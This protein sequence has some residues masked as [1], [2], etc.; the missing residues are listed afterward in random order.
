MASVFAWLPTVLE[1]AQDLALMSTSINDDRST[2][3]LLPAG[4]PPVCGFFVGALSAPILPAPVL[5]PIAA[6]V[7][8]DPLRFGMMLVLNIVIGM[9]IPRSAR[10]CSL[11]PTPGACGS[12]SAA[13]AKDL[14]FTQCRAADLSSPAHAVV[15]AFEARV[16]GETVAPASP[17]AEG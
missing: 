14:V 16:E 11:P 3:L 4:R 5:G 6:Q 12:K 17:R 1:I 10:S 15:L 7:G 2:P 9:I 13:A 8:A